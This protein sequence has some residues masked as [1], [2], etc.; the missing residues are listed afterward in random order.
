CTHCEANGQPTPETVSHFLFEC[1]TYRQERH[2]LRRS[3]GRALNSL[4]LL[5][6]CPHCKLKELF[7]YVNC[8]KWFKSAFGEFSTP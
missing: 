6:L 1:P 7:R 8:T 5:L 3:L 4:T 2:I